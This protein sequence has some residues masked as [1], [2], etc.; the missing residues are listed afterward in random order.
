M[1]ILKEQ[2]PER[3]TG[4]QPSDGTEDLKWWDS[5][6]SYLLVCSHSVVRGGTGSL[7]DLG[8]SSQWHQG[9]GEG[10]LTVC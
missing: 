3:Q 5:P 10:G 9:H 7:T 6:S 8:R 4:N 2:W 1:K